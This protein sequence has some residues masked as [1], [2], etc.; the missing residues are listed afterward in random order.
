MT[1]EQVSE[2]EEFWVTKSIAGEDETS[3]EDALLRGERTT[4]KEIIAM[5]PEANLDHV[6]VQKT[7][8]NTTPNTYVDNFLFGCETTDF[9]VTP[10]ADDDDDDDSNV[11]PAPGPDFGSL[12]LGGGLALAA[13]LAVGGGAF[14][15]Q[16]GMIQ[17]PPE[18][19]ALLP[20]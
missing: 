20:A 19:A 11:A 18:L 9:E 13:A 6:G 4:L 5:N 2:S 1:P 16:N 14:A 12:A 8:E 3:Y 17:L 7:R 15:I 10:P